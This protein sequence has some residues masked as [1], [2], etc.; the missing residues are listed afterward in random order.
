MGLLQIDLLRRQAE[1]AAR[2]TAQKEAAAVKE[3]LSLT[4]QASRMAGMAEDVLEKG[5]AAAGRWWN[6]RE[7]G[8]WEDGFDPF[9]PAKA[10]VVYPDGY[11][12]LTP[13]QPYR[14]PA[15]YRKRRMRRAAVAVLAAVFLAALVVVILRSGLLQF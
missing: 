2:R 11:V 13:V 6:S 8:L 14:T 4:R 3:K 9:A 15:G 12:R 7:E 10:P 5:A 1:G